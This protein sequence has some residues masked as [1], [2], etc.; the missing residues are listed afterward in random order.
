MGMLG[1]WLNW[2]DARWDN[3]RLKIRETENGR[4]LVHFVN[5]TGSI[6][7]QAGTLLN[8][9]SGEANRFPWAFTNIYKTWE[10]VD[11]R[12]EVPVREAKY[13]RF[14]DFKMAY[15]NTDPFRDLTIEDAK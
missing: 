8:S 9:E 7:G 5:D 15:D 14:V 12:K 3:T 2:Y 6:L 13:L 11:S 10:R 4:E 1:A